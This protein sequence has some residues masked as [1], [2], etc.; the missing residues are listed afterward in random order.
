M[1]AHSVENHT[2][3]R[4]RRLFGRSWVYGGDCDVVT[5]LAKGSRQ[6]AGAVL[7]NPG[8]GFAALLDK[9]H[10]LMQDLPNHAA[11]PMGDGPNG[12]FIAQPRQQTPEHRLEVTAFLSHRSVGSLVQ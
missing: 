6:T 4:L 10:S 1:T 2:L 8:I 3:L 12:G 11:E 5:E 9:S 7:P